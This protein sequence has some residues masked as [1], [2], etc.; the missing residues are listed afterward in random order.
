[1]QNRRQLELLPIR[2]FVLYFHCF[3]HCTTFVEP[4]LR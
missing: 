2:M 1:V 4:L 3:A